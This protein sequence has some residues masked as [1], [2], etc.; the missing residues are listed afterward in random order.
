MDDVGTRVLRLLDTT[1]YLHQAVPGLSGA[2]A[3]CRG[4]MRPADRG[5]YTTCFQCNNHPRDVFDRLGFGIYALSGG[6]SAADMIGYKAENQS[7]HAASIVKALTYQAIHDALSLPGPRFNSVVTVP[8]LSG[9]RGRHALDAITDAALHQFPEAPP[10]TRCLDGAHIRDQSRRRDTDPAHFV[11]L[12]TRP[13]GNVLLIDDT[14]TTG[15]HLTSAAMTLR[16]AG[17][18]GV[19]TVALCRWLQP[20]SAFTGATLFRESEKLT[21][22]FAGY[23]FFSGPRTPRRLF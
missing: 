4:A 17:A 3:V 10:L 16:K 8:S 23:D 21:G 5:R 6:Q 19:T 12:G 1:P 13:P 11:F 2:C 18:T 14:W 15:G 7:Q 22:P 9:R 20:D